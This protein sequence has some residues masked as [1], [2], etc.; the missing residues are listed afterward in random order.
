M[1]KDAFA[2]AL[3][4]LRDYHVENYDRKSAELDFHKI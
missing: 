1:S 3:D 4:D 2:N